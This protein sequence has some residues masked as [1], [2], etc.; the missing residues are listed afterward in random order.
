MGGLNNGQLDNQST[1]CSSTMLCSVTTNY[2]KD[3]NISMLHNGEIVEWATAYKLRSS[4]SLTTDMIYQNR[5]S[6]GKDSDL[7]TC[8]V[9]LDGSVIRE[10]SYRCSAVHGKPTLFSTKGPYPLGDS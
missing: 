4:D 10:A 3:F 8:Q 2:T 5:L 7:F 9:H 6:S 1:S